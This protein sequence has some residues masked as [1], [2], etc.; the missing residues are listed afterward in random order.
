LVKRYIAE[1]GSAWVQ[2]VCALDAGNSLYIS[3]I[4]GAEVVAAI[5]RR[6]RKVATQP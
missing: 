2:S 1:T 5:F 6:Q 4:T 3:R